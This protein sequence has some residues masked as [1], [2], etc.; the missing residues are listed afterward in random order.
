MSHFRNLLIVDDERLVATSLSSLDEWNDKQIHVIGTASNGKQALEWMDR[1]TIDIVITDI[2]MPDMDGLELLQSIYVCNP[3]VSVILISGHE[4]FHYARFALK[5][6][7]KGYVL[8]PIDTDELF[9]IVDEILDETRELS[10]TEE[11][12][13]AMANEREIPKT[14]HEKLVDL[15]IVFIKGNLNTTITLNDVANRHFLTPHY[16]GQIFKQIT[17]ETFVSYL[18]QLRM[19]KACELLKNAE[20]KQ[21]E[22][23]QQ[24]GYTDVKYFTKLFQRSYRMTPKEYRQNYFKA[25]R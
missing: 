21:Y 1:H 19:E 9:G 10:K 20:L 2:Q 17:G 22:I 13:V 5:Y 23:S 6:K 14:Y 3:K 4:Q 11:P 16:F 18:T 15:A 24:I 7:A 12:V 8:K 25:G